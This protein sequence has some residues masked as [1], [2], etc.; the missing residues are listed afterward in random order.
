MYIR[1]YVMLTYPCFFISYVYI[2]SSEA[3]VSA[4][5]FNARGLR[6]EEVLGLSERDAP[7]VQVQDRV[8]DGALS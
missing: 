8:G 3:Y 5:A 2:F 1:V 7:A 6:D 4:D